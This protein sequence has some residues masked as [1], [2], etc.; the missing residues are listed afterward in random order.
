MHRK[1][2]PT[3]GSGVVRA[4]PTWLGQSART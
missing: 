4:G 1:A 3:S 2:F